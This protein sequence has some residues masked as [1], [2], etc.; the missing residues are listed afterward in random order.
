M[1][2]IRKLLAVDDKKPAAPIPGDNPWTAAAATSDPGPTTLHDGF[3]AARRRTSFSGA[4]WMWAKRIALGMLL[5]SGFVQLVVRPVLNMTSSEQEKP[6]AVNQIDLKVAEASASGFAVD[7]LTSG[8]K[9]WEPHRAAA[10]SQWIYA[11]AFSSPS[12]VGVWDGDGVLLADSPS[13]IASQR[14][15]DDSAVVAVQIRV[16]SFVPGEGEVAKG[17]P[18]QVPDNDQQAF[19]PA[20]PGGYVAGPSYWL[21]LVVP[22]VNDDEGVYVSG[23]GPVFSAD[24]IAPV[25]EVGEV[26][27]RSSEELR[28]NAETLLNAYASADLEYVAADG[29]G[30]Q[31]MGGAVTV[32]SI[33]EG[34]VAKGANSDETVNAALTV[35]WELVGASVT[36]PQTYGLRL[37][38]VSSD[39]PQLDHISVIE[40]FKPTDNN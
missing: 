2:F 39:A 29:S 6:A 27:G 36:I 1:S 10:L 23:P 28:S 12:D 35:R 26:D 16:M 13:V 9:E 30:L 34:E 33:E 25:P 24:S 20:V 5:I 8:G 22:L 3:D 19:R 21:R 18:P 14:V 37:V 4:A 15:D 38:N 11:K 17:E 31:G 7:Y 40:P 32:S